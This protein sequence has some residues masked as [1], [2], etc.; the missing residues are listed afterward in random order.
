MH[1][2]TENNW[3]IRNVQNSP[4]AESCLGSTGFQFVWEMEK[5]I[6]RILWKLN[7][8]SRLQGSFQEGNGSQEESDAVARVETELTISFLELKP[9]ATHVFL[10]LISMVRFPPDTAYVSK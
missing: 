9:T 6:P 7:Y 5:L 2:R 4:Q 8:C 1:K 10:A 3:E